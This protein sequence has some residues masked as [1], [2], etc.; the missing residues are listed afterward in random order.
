MSAATSASSRSIDACEVMREIA[1]TVVAEHAHDVDQRARFPHEG[2][3][4]LRSGGLLG[5]LVPSELGGLGA[6]Y[7]EIARMCTELGRHCASTAMVFAM[8]QIQV[9]CVV[10]HGARQPHFK[11][12]LED[13]ACRGT[14]LA[15]ATTEAGIGGD[16]RSSSCA[17][18]HTADGEFTLTKQASVISYG[19]FADDVLVTARRDPNATA[20]DQVLVHV[21]RPELVLEPIGTWD[22]LGM[23][24]TC[25]IGF[26]LTAHGS[27]EQILD[28]PYA[29]ISSRTMLPVSHITWSALWLGIAEDAARKARTY[30][31][32]AARRTPGT[33]PASADRLARL[34]S[35]LEQLRSSLQWALDDLER[36]REDSQHANSLG[37][38]VRMNNLKV[39]MS[40]GALAVVQD[41]LTLCGIAGYRNDSEYSMGRSLRDAH[42]AEL[43]VHNDR[44]LAHNA[45][46]L[47]LMKDS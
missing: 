2:I 23:R 35:R 44:I 14:L 47:C 42:S 10:E 30:V 6:S 27:S 1:S 28:V 5:A 22:A 25:S 39:V 43:M 38:A 16:V 29:D 40:A 13:V 20:N 24:G 46:L 18:E 8:H 11:Q 31:Q 12:L 32:R 9:A 34:N 33:I 37:F 7:P 15:S 3:E 41:A 36:S 45:S 21:R 4:S 17:V 26:T 19:E